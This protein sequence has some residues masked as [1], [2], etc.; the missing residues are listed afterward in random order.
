MT[1]SR[2]DLDILIYLP[3]QAVFLHLGDGHTRGHAPAH[4][5]AHSACV[6]DLEQIVKTLLEDSTIKV[7]STH[8]HVL[9][10]ASIC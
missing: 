2:S 6:T 10:F 9:R 7:N 5:R 8:L 3:Q 4:V 1:N